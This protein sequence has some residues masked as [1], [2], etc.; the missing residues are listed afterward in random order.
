MTWHLIVGTDSRSVATGSWQ[1]DEYWCK[2]W[3]GFASAT[4][5]LFQAETSNT[6]GVGFFHFQ[7]FQNSV[8][9]YDVVTTHSPSSDESEYIWVDSPDSFYYVD[10]EL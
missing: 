5:L 3:T 9:R 1:K 2:T 7:I 6:N 10:L 4:Q 8:S